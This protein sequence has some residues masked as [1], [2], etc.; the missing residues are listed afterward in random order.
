MAAD[1]GKGRGYNAAGAKYG[2]GYCDALLGFAGFLGVAG[3][4]FRCGFRF[5]LCQ[6]FYR[7]SS[8]VTAGVGVAS[9]FNIRLPKKGYEA[10]NPRP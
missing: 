8:G 6:G 2:T 9:L 7:A 1:G 3:F 4:G 5:G 10:L